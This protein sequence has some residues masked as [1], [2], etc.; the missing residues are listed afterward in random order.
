MSHGLKD[1]V[2]EDTNK[3]DKRNPTENCQTT[4][5]LG[6]FCLS[7]GTRELCSL[8]WITGNKHLQGGIQITV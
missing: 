8:S 2:M 4:R 5:N 7:Q 1:I 3:K 6:F